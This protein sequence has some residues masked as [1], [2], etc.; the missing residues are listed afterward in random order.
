MDE[1]KPTPGYI[2][3]YSGALPA[4]PNHEPTGQLLYE[5]PYDEEK[6]AFITNGV[7]LV[8][9]PTNL[10]DLFDFIAGRGRFD[11]VGHGGFHTHPGLDERSNNVHN[12]CL[13]L[14]QLRLI[15][16]ALNRIDHVCWLVN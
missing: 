9:P 8:D 3:I 5:F 6:H 12:A 1:Q 7:D 2:R 11:W 4:L 14:E 16:R 13:E 10:M 15:R